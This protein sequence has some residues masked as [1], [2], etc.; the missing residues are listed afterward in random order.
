MLNDGKKPLGFGLSL[1]CQLLSAYMERKRVNETHLAALTIASV[2]K[3][4][5]PPPGGSSTQHG[6]GAIRPMGSMA[7][8][9]TKHFK[10]FLLTLQVKSTQHTYGV[11]LAKGTAG[12]QRGG[13]SMKRGELLVER[14]VF[15]LA[16]NHRYSTDLFRRRVYWECPQL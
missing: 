8:C 1:V 12:Y 13:E 6:R 2:E 5:A 11:L 7:N 15:W 4:V 14:P 16:D 10:R 3:Q 9:D